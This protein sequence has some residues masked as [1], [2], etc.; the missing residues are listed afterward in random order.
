MI[1]TYSIK[2]LWY[3]YSEEYFVW[4]RL[5][6]IDR[7]VISHRLYPL[8]LLWRVGVEPPI[9]FSKRKGGRGGLF[10]HKTYHIFFLAP[11]VNIQAYP[12]LPWG[13]QEVQNRNW[14]NIWLQITY[15][16]LLKELFIIG[17]FNIIVVY[18]RVKTTAP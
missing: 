11:P 15:R 17:L 14:N 8:F 13:I 10:L 3:K 5:W 18:N 7:E 4:K 12:R 6:L 2:L 16:F 1:S 9:K